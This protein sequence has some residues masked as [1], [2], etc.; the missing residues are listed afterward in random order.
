MKLSISEK[1]SLSFDLELLNSIIGKSFK[2]DKFESEMRKTFKKKSS[3]KLWSNN[4]SFD[5][6]DGKE[7][8][9]VN[10]RCCPQFHKAMH[11]F[12]FVLD[13]S[14]DYILVKDGFLAAV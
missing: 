9:K 13:T 3:C 11:I 14:Q 6:W 10:Y 1:N 7:Y 5:L 12:G 2:A 4:E 8:H